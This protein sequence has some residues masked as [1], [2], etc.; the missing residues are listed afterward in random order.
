MDKASGGSVTRT[1]TYYPLGGAMRVDGTWYYMLKDHLGSASVLTNA[2]G[3]AVSGADVRYYPFGEARSSTASMLTDKL[4][5]GQREMAG[6]GIYHYQARF[7]SPKLGRFLSADTIVPNFANPQDLNRY[8]YVKNSPINYTDPSG[9][10]YLSG[11]WMPDTDSACQW[12]SNNEDSLS[13][14]G[15]GGFVSN[16]GGN[17]DDNRPDPSA[18]EPVE[19]NLGG[20]QPLPAPYLNTNYYQLTTNAL[21]AGPILPPSPFACGWFDCA[22]SAVSLIA[23][24]FTLA[25]DPRVAVPAWLLMEGPQL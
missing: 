15:N 18:G 8:T 22:L 2:S 12:A 16:G 13:G 19:P 24:A 5:T 6:L 7:Y 25:K 3:N 14:S 11:H 10:C 21:F 1:V 23:S 20:S 17:D 9:R 4:Y